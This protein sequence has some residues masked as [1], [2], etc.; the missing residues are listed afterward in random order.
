MAYVYG[1]ITPGSVVDADLS[2]SANLSATK[3]Q[4]QYCPL[5]AQANS[6]AASDTG[7][8]I[9]VV[10][11]ATG[12]MVA[13]RAGSIVAATGNATVTIDLKKNGT[14]M[15]TAVI[16]LDNANTAYIA[17]DAALSVTALAAGDVLTL[18]IVATVGTGVLPT[19][20]FAEAILREDA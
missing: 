12:T 17:E 5:F 18:V 15:L 20:L 3:M 10:K 7:R 13:F 8:V 2:A 19:G 16:T 6:A 11:G 9:H 1:T 14:T 4:H